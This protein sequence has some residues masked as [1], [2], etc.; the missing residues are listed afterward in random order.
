M[1]KRLLKANEL[2]GRIVELR[3]ELVT[4]DGSRRFEAGSY[5]VVYSRC[6]RGFT[7]QRLDR[8]PGEKKWSEVL[9]H[10]PRSAIEIPIGY[11]GRIHG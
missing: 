3:R 8:L 11:A 7:L 2:V 6:S 9:R 1:G 10:V 4:R 5:W